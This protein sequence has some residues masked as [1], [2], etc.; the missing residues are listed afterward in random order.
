MMY[1]LT[2]EDVIEYFKKQRTERAYR[3]L[4]TIA[5]MIY[6]RQFTS[7]AKGAAKKGNKTTSKGR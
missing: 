3:L 1:G 6:D 4:D 5:D 7:T 2:K